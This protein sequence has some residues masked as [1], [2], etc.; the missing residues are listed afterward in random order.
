MFAAP[1]VCAHQTTQ[2]ALSPPSHGNQ[3]CL[4]TPVRACLRGG[5]AAP[6]GE[7]LGETRG[8]RLVHRLLDTVN[9]AAR[10]RNT[11]R[12][13]CV[14]PLGLLSR[15][16]GCLP[17]CVPTADCPSAPPAQREAR[18]AGRGEWL[19]ERKAPGGRVKPA[20]P[21]GSAARG[22]HTALNEV[23]PPERAFPPA[24][25]VGLTGWALEPP[26]PRP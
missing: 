14:S 6:C 21:A 2:G 11:A 20:P 13:G 12:Y 18:R 7:P 17:A 4:W 16:T 3:R 15:V 9:V 25:W 1:L 22:K 8:L 10:K 24:A 23:P 26:H 19:A 5:S